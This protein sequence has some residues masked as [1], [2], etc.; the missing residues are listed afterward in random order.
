ML[1]AETCAL[2][3][4]ATILAHW[5]LSA[6]SVEKCTR[7][8]VL[9]S[10]LLLISRESADSETLASLMLEDSTQMLNHHVVHRR[11]V[12]TM[13]LRMETLSRGGLSDQAEADF[14]RLVMRGIHLSN[15]RIEMSFG[16]L[17]RNWLLEASCATSTHC[18]ATQ[19][20]GSERNQS[21]MRARKISPMT[22]Q[23]FLDSKAGY[24][25][26]WKDIEVRLGRRLRG[27]TRYGSFRGDPPRRGPSN[28]SAP[29][30][31]AA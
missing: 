2:S 28:P 29:S 14:L 6:S 19:T 23:N 13:L 17:F 25:R 10:T 12:G 15:A 7:M 18:V 1:S 20:G 24:E 27:A 11:K 16:L 22:R 4:C 3:R 26:I 21:H 30:L 5:E 31:E 9:I 8:G